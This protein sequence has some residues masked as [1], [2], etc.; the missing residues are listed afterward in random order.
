MK[1]AVYFFIFIA[2][3]NTAI[4]QNT[5]CKVLLPQIAGQYQGDCK[6]GL[7]HG[8]GTAQG[9]DR[10]EGQFSKGIPEG[11]GTYTYASGS[12]YIGSWEKGM[13]EGKG[14]MVYRDSVVVGYW[15]KDKYV[16]NEKPVPYKIISSLS[17]GRYTIVKSNESANRIRLRL[18]QGGND[19][20]SVEGFSMA[21]DSGSEYSSGNYYGIEN[22]K[23]PLNLKIKYTTA[24]QLL[25]SRFQVIFELELRE[26]GTWDI[27]IFN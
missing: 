9:T 15:H 26:P 17:V 4:A 23:F 5:D 16:G 20:L 6:N 14:K 25:T 2:A 21:Y 11:K 24:N 1:R 3:W 8:K 12:V 10:Y 18:K 27:T 19:N 22:V 13:K 7:A